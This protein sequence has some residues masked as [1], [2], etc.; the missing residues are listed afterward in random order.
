[1][2]QVQVNDHLVLV[3]G[4]SATGKSA[5]L[6][7]LQKPE[8]VMYLNCESGKRLPFR[9]KFQ[10]FTITDPLQ[11]EEAFAV[12]ETKP[13]VHTIVVDSLTYL[14]DMY[15]SLH[16]LTASNTMKAW[17]EY[18]QFFKRIMQQHVAR[19]S[20]NVVFIGHTLTTLNEA[21]GVMETKVPIKGSIKNQGIESYFS[22]V[23]SA[24]KVP[25]KKLE[26]YSSPLLEVTAEEQALGYKYVFQ[27]KLTKDTVNERIRSPMG[28]W[29]NTE[30]YI[31]NSVQKV[32]DRLHEYYE[33]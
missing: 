7:G 14:M 5:C 21:E 23:I 32:F 15:E 26:G 24:K 20:K 2:S 22:C 13:E 28:M 25:L 11:V 33:A 10:E 12:A 30:T 29:E 9:S 27:T 4:E 19:S 31:D 17:S 18:N 16:V 8:G 1:M 3:C 6:M